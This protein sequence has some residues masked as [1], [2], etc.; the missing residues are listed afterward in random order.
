MPSIGNAFNSTSGFKDDNDTNF[1]TSYVNLFFETNPLLIDGN[2]TTN[3]A[4]PLNDSNGTYPLFENVTDVQMANDRFVVMFKVVTLSIILGFMILITVIGNVFVICAIILERNLQNVANYLV[5][6]LAVADLFVACLVMPL[7]AVYEISEGWIMGPELCDIWTSCDVLC[8]TASILHLVAIAADRYWTVTNIDYGNI[9]TP[10]RIFFMII[11]IWI[12]AITVSV[13]PQFGW[14]DPEYLK[15]IEERKCMVSQNVTYQIFATFATFYI[16][17]LIILLLYWKIYKI[18]QKRIKRRLKRPLA[19]PLNESQLTT[20]PE[21]KR[22]RLEICFGRHCPNKKRVLGNNLEVTTI[23]TQEETEFST[24]NFDSRSHGTEYTAISIDPDDIQTSSADEITT[25]SYQ[26]ATTISHHAAAMTTTTSGRCSNLSTMTDELAK[27]RK[28]IE[29][30]RERKAAQT[31]AIITGAFV[32]CWLPFF[33][34]ALVLT[35]CKY[36]KLNGVLASL[37]LWLGYFNSSLNPIIYT[38]FNPEFRRAFKRLI[39]GRLLFSQTNSGK[40]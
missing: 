37:F 29:A 23:N 32:C 22:R 35:L 38:I 31:L 21:L 40:I 3:K 36:C 18:A 34:T 5:A 6:S 9:R 19:G 26:V 13:A 14:K 12:V 7:G 8:C 1:A 10:T 20:A 33:V 27:R 4:F 25:V 39:H 28:L 11:C 16:P 17:L 15:R 24:S 2:D 30:K